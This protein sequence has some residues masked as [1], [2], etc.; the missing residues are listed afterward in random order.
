V[1]RYLPS[2]AQLESSALLLVRARQATRALVAFFMCCNRC[3]VRLRLY[4][5]V[6]VNVRRL[7]V[8]LAD[9]QNNLARGGDVLA[10]GRTAGLKQRKR[11]VP[12]YPATLRQY[13]ASPC[14]QR[15]CAF[16]ALRYAGIT[17]SPPPL[18]ASSTFT[19]VGGR[20]GRP[21]SGA[22]GTRA[23]CYR[24]A[25]FCRAGRACLLVA[26]P[27][28]HCRLRGRNIAPAFISGSAKP[29]QPNFRTR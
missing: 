13:H 2:A 15:T 16:S 19:V 20:R 18:N 25:A 1:R 17:P 3:S 11:R 24:R 29:R 28:K 8:Y 26:R 7:T 4:T 14:L 9:A 6:G 23:V 22:A 12:V 10:G 27:C 21:L 5:F